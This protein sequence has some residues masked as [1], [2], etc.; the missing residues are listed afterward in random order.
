[1]SGKKKVL[2]MVAHLG[3]RLQPY[4][5]RLEAEGFEVLQL[6]ARPGEDKLIQALQG[7][8]GTIAALEIYNDRVFREAKD[9][10]IVAR[11][12]VGYDT[13][14]VE[15]ATR[16][17]VVLAMAFG[18]NHE[19]V[20][21]WTLT[22]MGAVY[23]KLLQG[24]RRVVGGGWGHG[25]HPG[26][27][28][29]TVGLI[30]LG[31]IGKAVARRCRG[32][33]MRLLATDILPD[34]AFAREQGI[35]FVPLETLLREAD[36]VSLHAPHSPVTEKLINRATLALMKPT[37]ILVNTARGGLVDEDALYQALS[38]GGI[39]GAGLDVFCNE[40]PVGSPLLALDNIVLSPHE[41][42]ND[43]TS[44]AAVIT[45]CVESI[46]A[47]AHGQ[48]PGPEY[49]VNPMALQNGQRGTPIPA[50]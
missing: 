13:V 30:G 24:H 7:V 21:D 39:A 44:E 40:P 50:A 10:R 4:A 20:A 35:T 29:K 6:A 34:E 42:G 18:C 15:A 9:L 11:F 17:G 41:A 46:L 14:D 25:A 32:F 23:G 47:V 28:R 38:G 2:V 3:E 36:I 1:M 49:V 27:W 8:F 22:L 12:G 19:G 33:E 48:H 37:A 43:L 26:L 16:H 45:R 5:R 31:R